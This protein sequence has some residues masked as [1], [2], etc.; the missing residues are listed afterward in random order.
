MQ[1]AET[2]P[3]AL[4]RN[5]ELKARCL[6]LS[7]AREAVR[8][9]GAVPAGLEI[10]VDT[11]FSVPKGWLKLR[12]ISGQPAVLI[13]YNRPN[14][15]GV[16]A[17]GYYLVPVPDPCV[18]RAALATALG[19]RGEVHKER[20]IYLWHNVRIHLDDV[21]GLGSFLEFE[22]VLSPMDDEA[23]SRARLEQLCRALAIE[24]ADTQAASY[25]DL[26]GL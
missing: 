6:D 20:D 12:E 13:C 17:S 19:V 21:A 10:Q 2:A 23:M 22:A 1:P 26:L 3:K 5:L 18:L 24:T 9:L 15:D 7:A 25:A 4:R 8:R 11:Y 16:R 14:Q